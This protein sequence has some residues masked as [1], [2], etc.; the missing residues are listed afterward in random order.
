MVGF[1]EVCL[2]LTSVF[3]LTF[4]RFII[5][6]NDRNDSFLSR[7]LLYNSWDFELVTQGNLERECMEEICSYEEAREVF[8]DN[9]K[10]CPREDDSRRT[11]GSGDGSSDQHHHSPGLPSYREA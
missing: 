3:H 2:G 9:Q 5:N 6:N 1:T 7:S 11:S 10:A 8:D 4:A